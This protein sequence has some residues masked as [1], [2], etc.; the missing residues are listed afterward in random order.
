V[1]LLCIAALSAWLAIRQ[2]AIAMAAVGVVGGFL[3]PILTSSNTGNHVLLFGYYALLNAG[4]FG[5]AWFKAWRSLNLLGFLFT[6]V[7]GTFWGVTRY[8]ADDFATTEPFLILFFLF[9]VAIAV[10][11]ALRQSL[12]LRDYVDGALVFGTPLFAAGLQSGMVRHMPYG[13]AFSR[14]HPPCT[15]SGELLYARHSEHAP[16]RR[17][18]SARRHLDLAI[19]LT[20]DAR[21]TSATW[22]RRRGDVVGRCAAASTRGA[23]VRI[24]AANRCRHRVR[25]GSDHLAYG[26]A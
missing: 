8:R 22:G 19:P 17:S 12:A 10:L 23:G 3:A 15:L 9:Y 5:I 6:F 18:F 26:C 7:I 11:Y 13:M 20:L 2:D 16:A 1:L 24:A 4:I 25:V 14:R 21:W